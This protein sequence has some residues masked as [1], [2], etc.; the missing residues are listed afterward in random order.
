[1]PGDLTSNDRAVFVFLDGLALALLFA[2]VEWLTSGKPWPLATVFFV[3]AFVL[4]L[5]ATIGRP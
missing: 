2:D 1:M 5:I 4:A 3:I